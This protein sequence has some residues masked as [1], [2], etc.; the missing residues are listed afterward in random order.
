MT[1]TSGIFGLSVSRH[2]FSK[3]NITAK[4]SL[5]TN[6]AT[7]NSIDSNKYFV[8]DAQSGN[9]IPYF[10]GKEIKL[11]HL[12]LQ[13]DL[14][15]D[16]KLSDYFYL[17]GGFALN[18]PLNKKANVDEKLIFPPGY[19]F[20]DGG[21]EKRISDQLN[22]LSPSYFG[23]Y[24]GPGIVCNIGR[25]FQVFTDINYYFFPGSLLSDADLFQRQVNIKF[26]L[27]YQL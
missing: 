9:K 13:T 2:L 27:K 15:L 17:S 16:W 25:G 19:E 14:G 5:I 6:D 24:I 23:L 18:L 10:V 7:F 1:G 11:K 21:T 26:G 22:S 12:G 3:F 8:E 20:A 4:L